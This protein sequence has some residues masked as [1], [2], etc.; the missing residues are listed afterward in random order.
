MVHPDAGA[1]Q[2]SRILHVLRRILGADQV[3]DL[4]NASL[5]SPKQW[6]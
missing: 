1:M 4:A 2:G 5:Q 3:C 6:Y